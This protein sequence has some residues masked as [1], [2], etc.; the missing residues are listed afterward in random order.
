MKTEIVLMPAALPGE[1]EGTF[2]NTQRLIQW[3]DKVVEPRGDMRSDLWFYY[4]LG[5][6]L[7]ALY[8]DSADPKD[9]PLKN[10][11]WD[12]PTS[13]PAEEP[14]AG[15]V[16]KEINGYTW[17]DRKL[18]AKFD[19]IKD[20]GS[21]ACGCWIYTGVYP[22]DDENKARS[23]K[24]D[25]PDGPGSHLGWGFAWP[26]NRRI[27]YNRASADPDGKP[28]SER[29]R[30]AWWDPEQ[31]KWTGADVPDFEETKRPD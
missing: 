17:P 2:T 16:L 3:H 1:K 27:L 23:R 15:A 10:L 4:H 21:T 12:Y 6:R 26:A 31:E 28:W 24:A 29:K 7:K 5:R 30:Y 19:D 25:G 11:T 13:G 9:E 18:I 14:S 20:D 8:A 22:H